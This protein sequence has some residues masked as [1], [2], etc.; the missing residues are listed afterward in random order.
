VDDDGRLDL[1][2]GTKS[3]LLLLKNEGTPDAPAFSSPTAIELDGSPQRATPDFGDLNNDG[4]TELVV[5]TKRGGFVLFQP[6]SS[7]E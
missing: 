7:P 2:L 6:R 1:L 4:R 3:E 5:G